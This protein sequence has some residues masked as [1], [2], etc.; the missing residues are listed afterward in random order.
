MGG[1]LFQ[2]GG[3]KPGAAGANHPGGQFREHSLFL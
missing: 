1:W 3:E 2:E